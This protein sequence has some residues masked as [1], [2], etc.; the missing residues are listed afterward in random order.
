MSKL[1]G[2]DQVYTD[3]RE[4]SIIDFQAPV[5]TMRSI[6][7]F[8]NSCLS[9]PLGVLSPM[10]STISAGGD[11]TSKVSS[12]EDSLDGYK[13]IFDLVKQIISQGIGGIFGFYTIF[14]I[15]A[16]LCTGC[17]IMRG[18]QCLCRCFCLNLTWMLLLYFSF[19]VIFLG[20]F[21]GILSF[22]VILF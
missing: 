7:T 6:D 11:Y 15:N 12:F 5:L 2:L 8:I 10:L 17:T 9:N 20:F 14:F 13:D 21:S 4:Q 3:A 1:Q 19:V 22:F 16:L 18:D